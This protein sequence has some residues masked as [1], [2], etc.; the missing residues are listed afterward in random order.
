MDLTRAVQPGMERI[1]K[2]LVGLCAL[3]TILTTV[4]IIIT[5]LYTA[6]SFFSEYSIWDFLTGT[7]WSPSIKPVAFGVLPLVTGTLIITVGSALI[8]VPLGVAAAVYLSEFARPWVRKTLKPLL[9]ILAGVP[10]IVYGYFALVYITPALRTVLRRAS[11]GAIELSHYNALSA[12]IVVGIMIIPLVASISEDAM[13]SVPRSLRM[14]GYAL[15]ASKFYVVVR[16]V[17]PA[18]FSGIIASFI[19]AFSR[20]IGETMAVTL[21]AGQT[22][23]DYGRFEISTVMFK[24]IETMTAAMVDLGTGDIEG[25]SVAYRSLFAI[26]LTLFA[27][28]FLMNLLGAVVTSKFREKYE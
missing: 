25:F 14:A 15:G 23:I 21:A 26:G 16:V 1:V 19:L 11:G 3:V 24:P 4:G 5:L 12:C 18:A 6:G 8:A 28:T 2:S 10:T 17:I 9:E 7:K 22:P 13:R 20:A 27:L